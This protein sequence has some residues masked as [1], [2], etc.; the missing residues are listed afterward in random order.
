MLCAG[1][2]ANCLVASIGDA[3]H[4]MA[5]LEGHGATQALVDA[6]DL[7][8]TLSDAHARRRSGEAGGLDVHKLP[9]LLAAFHEKMARR[10]ARRVLN[11]RS[12]LAFCHTLAALQVELLSE[13]LNLKPKAR[14]EEPS[15]PFLCQPLTQA[16]WLIHSWRS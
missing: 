6:V 1:H 5:P 14:T 13:R 11:S 4:P 9:R 15:V 3:A 8:R 7:A 16:C 2:N 12:N 10:V